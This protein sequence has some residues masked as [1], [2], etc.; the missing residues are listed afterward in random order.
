MSY[1]DLAVHPRYV[2]WQ[3]GLWRRFH[4]LGVEV[5]AGAWDDKRHALCGFVTKARTASSA[6]LYPAEMLAIIE[7]MEQEKEAAP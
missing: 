6:K 7:I 5:Y 3:D 1:E 2:T 4:A